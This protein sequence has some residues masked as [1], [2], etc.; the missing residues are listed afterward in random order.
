MEIGVGL[1]G[2]R[3]PEQREADRVS[4]DPAG[5]KRLTFLK[6][7]LMVVTVAVVSDLVDTG[8]RSFVPWP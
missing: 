6:G 5:G 8:L 1:D 7:H 3:S 4:A 2:R